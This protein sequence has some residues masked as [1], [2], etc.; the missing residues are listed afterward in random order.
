MAD[1]NR[2]EYL[3]WNI[4]TLFGL[5]KRGYCELHVMIILLSDDVAY[6]EISTQRTNVSQYRIGRHTQIIASLLRTSPAKL[7]LQYYIAAAA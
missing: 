5:T 6:L 2:L 1:P 4:V 3:Q 7:P